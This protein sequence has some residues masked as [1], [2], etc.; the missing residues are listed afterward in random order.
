MQYT[1]MYARNRHRAIVLPD[2][3]GT[4]ASP[5]RIFLYADVTLSKASELPFRS[6]GYSLT[7]SRKLQ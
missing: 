2:D 1:F 6:C 5:S 7:L 4:C 3:C